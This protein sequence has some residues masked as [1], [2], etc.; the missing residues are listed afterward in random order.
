MCTLS[1]PVG[2]LIAYNS[3]RRPVTDLESTKVEGPRGPKDDEELKEDERRP[4]ST[5]RNL[6]HPGGP[7]VD[8]R[9]TGRRETA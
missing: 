1:S 6:G 8:K 4:S 3:L 9:T 2:K 7:K 5:L